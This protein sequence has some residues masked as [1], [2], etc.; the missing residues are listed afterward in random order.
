[1][2]VKQHGFNNFTSMT[3]TNRNNKNKNTKSHRF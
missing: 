1:M 3:G 2:Y